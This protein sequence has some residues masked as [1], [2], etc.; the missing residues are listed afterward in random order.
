MDSGS[1]AFHAIMTNLNN[2]LF[3]LV[4]KNFPAFEVGLE[5][6]AQKDFMVQ[7]IGNRLTVN[8]FV[9]YL[10]Y[11]LTGAHR[12]GVEEWDKFYRG[13]MTYQFPFANV[14]IS[15]IWNKEGLHLSSG[16]IIT[17]CSIVG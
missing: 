2:S 16:D 4:V 14:Y 11:K 12:S 13:G 1:F 7:D 5:V 10:F 6:V 9:L 15:Y 17:L 8:H 3:V